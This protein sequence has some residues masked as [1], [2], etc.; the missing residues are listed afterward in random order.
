MDAELVA[1][2]T[3]AASALVHE[4]TNDSWMEVRDRVTRILARER[5][6]QLGFIETELEESRI[7]VTQ[8]HEMGDT[9][10]VADTR[11]EWRSRMMRLLAAD[12]EAV[13]QL[14]RLLE[15]L[16]SESGSS[17]VVQNTVSGGGAHV[18][19]ARDIRGN[20]HSD[21]RNTPPGPPFDDE[22]EW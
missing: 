2:A 1:L 9:E 17:G 19:Q 18:I 4:M 7:F 16:A 3:A 6:G 12:P 22:D 10:T 21:S 15:E 8:A 20:V 14:R 11:A 13:T 5:E